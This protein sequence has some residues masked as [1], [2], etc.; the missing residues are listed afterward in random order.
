MKKVIVIS[1]II[2]LNQ[3]AFAQYSKRYR[4]LG[5]KAF[6]NKNYV[7]AADY[8]KKVTGDVKAHISIP[9]YARLK[10][11]HNKINPDL[12]YLYYQVGESYRL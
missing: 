3:A 1:L 12:D 10:I 8:Y 9:F 11:S 7:Q 5:D 4:N 6:G 2:M